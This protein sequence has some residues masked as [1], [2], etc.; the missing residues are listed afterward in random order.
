MDAF[1]ARQPILD[2]D[3]QIVGYELLFRSSLEN[4]FSHPDA[5]H[6]AAQVIHD[7]MHVFGLDVLAAGRRVFVNAT[8][9]VVV[10]GLYESLPRDQAVIELLESVEPDDE[11]IAACRRLKTAGYT[12]ALDD[13]VWDDRFERLLPWVDVVKVDFHAVAGDQLRDLV[14]RLRRWPLRLLAE[15]VETGE[16]FSAALELGFELF[17]G[18]FFYRPEILSVRALTPELLRLAMLGLAVDRG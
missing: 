17:Q 16:E 7:S 5:D 4:F 10:E 2:R 12:L 14:T 18:Y 1:V 15:K 13:F 6:A 8:R 9:Q 11:V 3:R